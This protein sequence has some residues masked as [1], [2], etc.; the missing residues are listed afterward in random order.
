VNARLAAT[1]DTLRNAL[2]SREAMINSL[3]APDVQTI[4]LSANVNAAGARMYV[5]RATQQVILAAYQLPPAPEGRI[6]QLWGITKGSTPVSLGTFNTAA[7]GE[8]RYVAT[9]PAGLTID[10]GAITEEPAGGSPQPTST[11]FLVGQVN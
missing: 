6:Y 2:A 8:A 7:N 9:A 3:L 11:P 4:R 10:V 1:S 5:N